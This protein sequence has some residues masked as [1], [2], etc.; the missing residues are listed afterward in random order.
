[1]SANAAVAGVAGAGSPPAIVAVAVG[2]A[3]AVGGVGPAA[4]AVGSTAAAFGCSLT[5]TG[6]PLT[7]TCSL[8][9]AAGVEAVSSG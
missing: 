9:A 5:A 3:F 4:A 1:V 2:T 7:A 6:S 8:P